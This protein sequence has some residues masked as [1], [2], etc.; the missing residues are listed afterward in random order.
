MTMRFGA[1]VLRAYDSGF[2]LEEVILNAGPADGEVL[3]RIAGC[4]MCR[5]DLAVRRSAGRSPLPAVLG[6]EGA[7]TVAETGG[8]DTGLSVGDHVVLS[9]DSCGRCRTCMRAAPAYCDSFASLNLYGGAR[10]T[11][12]DSPTRPGASWLPGGSDSRRSPSTRSPRPATPSGSIPRFP[13]NCSA[14]SA[15]ASSPVPGRSSTP[16]V[17]APATPS[18]SSA[19]E[20]WAWPR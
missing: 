10:R 5:T 19:R 6:H 9:F 7:G 16:S 4:G 1:A 15:A 3:V 17:P 11:R 20:R 14:R 13:S 2:A 12:A 18:R 8:G